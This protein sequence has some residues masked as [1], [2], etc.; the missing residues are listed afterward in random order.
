M[1]VVSN[2]HQWCVAGNQK[3][4]NNLATRAPFSMFIYIY[5]TEHLTM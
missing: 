1:D 4:L 2:Q 5:S 3:S